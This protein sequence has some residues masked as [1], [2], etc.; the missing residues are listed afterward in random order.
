[1]VVLDELRVDSRRRAQGPAVV[2]LEEKA[3]AV[4]K[5]ARLDDEYVRDVRPV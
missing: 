3:P 5:N 2:T 4:G 1:M